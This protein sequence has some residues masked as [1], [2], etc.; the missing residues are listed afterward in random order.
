MNNESPKTILIPDND[1]EIALSPLEYE[2]INFIIGK[3]N[4]K[5]DDI[6]TIPLEDE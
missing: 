4:N 6:L 1:N 2:I 3:V 5:L